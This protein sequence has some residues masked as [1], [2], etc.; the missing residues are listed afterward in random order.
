M[1]AAQ[2][3]LTW[4]R[5]QCERA[6]ISLKEV[7]SRSRKRKVS[8][9]RQA[10]MYGLKVEFG[11]SSNEIGRLLGGID[12]T[13]VIHGIKV[14]A[15]RNGLPVPVSKVGMQEIP[16]SKVVGVVWTKGASPWRVK[17]W[18]K[19]SRQY[20]GAY[21]TQEEAEAV[22]LQF[23]ATNKTVAWMRSRGIL[24]KSEVNDGK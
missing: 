5:E 19:L 3:R 23:H 8:L 6:G 16:T 11:S 1:E 22:A 14:H 10:L 15:S 21:A 7:R 13:T 18:H 9:L 20:I 2:P 17:I 24:V 4:V 12:H